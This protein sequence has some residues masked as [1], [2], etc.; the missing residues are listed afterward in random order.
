MHSIIDFPPPTLCAPTVHSIMPPKPDS[1]LTL[2][3]KRLLIV[4]AKLFAAVNE[5]VA[6]PPTTEAHQNYWNDMVKEEMVCYL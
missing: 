6:R 5:Y 1:E 2:D 3:E 4:A